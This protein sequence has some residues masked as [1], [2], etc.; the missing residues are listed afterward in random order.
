MS[1]LVHRFFKNIPAGISNTF[2]LT[3]STFSPHI[4]ATYVTYNPYAVKN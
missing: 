1:S 2:S 3:F 4:I